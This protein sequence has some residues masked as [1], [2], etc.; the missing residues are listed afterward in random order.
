MTLGYYADRI[1][2]L[3]GQASIDVELGEAGYESLL[4]VINNDL[5]MRYTI[6]EDPGEPSPE[7]D[8]DPDGTDLYDETG[9]VVA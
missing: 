1:R 2:Q 3:L 6:L 4:D 5:D 9:D 8:D 7:D